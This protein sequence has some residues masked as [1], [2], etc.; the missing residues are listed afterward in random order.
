MGRTHTALPEPVSRAPPGRFDPDTGSGSATR[1]K[2]RVQKDNKD[3]M[4]E[5]PFFMRAG[6]AQGIRQKV[7]F[8]HGKEDSGEPRQ[9]HVFE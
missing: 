2:R 1:I 7:K 4:E 3:L 8:Y 9:N 5:G 6:K